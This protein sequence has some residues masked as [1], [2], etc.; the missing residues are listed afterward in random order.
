VIKDA[1]TGAPVA[2]ACLQLVVPLDPTT[3]RGGGACSGPDGTVTMT[4]IRPGTYNAFVNVH[5]GVHG[6]QWVGL[7]R[8][9]GAQA[10][11]RPI[12]LSDGATFALPAIKLD[13]AS[14]VTGTIR[15]QATGDPL[16]SAFVG[17]ASFNSGLGETGPGTFTDAAGKYTVGDLGPYAWTF[18]FRHYGHAS[19]FSGGAGDRFLATGV[20]LTAG[21]TTT[22]DLSMRAGTLLTGVITNADGSPLTTFVRLTLV[23]ALSGDELYISDV[24]GSQPYE[25]HVASPLLVK[26]RID[27]GI[28]GDYVGGTDFFSAKVFLVGTTSPQ[29]QNISLNP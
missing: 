16:E 15:D 11:A 26:L 18:F 17:V 2:G 21:Q 22:Y 12:L 5:D 23:H 8:G 1:D 19:V 20:K 27:G 9:T 29:V 13:K 14:T 25:L 7:L 4:G 10:K 28:N 6:M 3:L 24:T